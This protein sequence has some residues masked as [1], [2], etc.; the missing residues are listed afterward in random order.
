MYFLIGVPWIIVGFI[1]W[2]DHYVIKRDAA[3]YDHE[4][5]GWGD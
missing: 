2:W 5:D 4:F 3:D 1:A